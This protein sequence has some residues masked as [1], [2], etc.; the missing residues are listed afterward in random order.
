MPP[1][2]CCFFI[3]FFFQTASWTACSQIHLPWVRSPIRPRRG[4]CSEL[5]LAGPS[6]PSEKSYN[7]IPY[8][9]S[10][11]LLVFKIFFFLLLAILYGIWDASSPTRDG[12]HSSCSGSVES[13]TMDCQGSPSLNM[14]WVARFSQASWGQS[15]TDWIQ[16]F[17]G[18]C[19]VYTCCA[20]T[21]SQQLPPP[22]TPTNS[23]STSRRWA[24]E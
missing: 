1:D 14:F 9:V 22:R 19:S 16:H 15:S 3:F 4:P 21:H 11:V 6:S 12:T 13:W 18:P 2:C 23:L 24:V 20:E 5:S 17:A 8:T 7:W 10:L